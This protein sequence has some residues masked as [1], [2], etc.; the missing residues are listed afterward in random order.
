MLI[1]VASNG[2]KKNK[3]Y[4]LGLLD[5][6]FELSIRTLSEI[7]GVSNSSTYYYISALL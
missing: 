2:T 7:V 3:K 5:E 6:N 4:G 1:N